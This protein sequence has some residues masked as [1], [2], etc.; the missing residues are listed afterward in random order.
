L[1][2]AFVQVNPTVGDLVGN[3]SMIASAAG[4][5]RR[6]GFDLAVT[7]ELALMEEIIAYG[8]D[9]PTVECVLRMVGGVEFKRKEAATGLKVTSGAFGAGFRMPIVREG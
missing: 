4:D 7:P 5:A 9:A 1:R 6:R 2:I 3:A 8:Y